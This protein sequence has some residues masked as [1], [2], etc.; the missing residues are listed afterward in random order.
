MAIA[1]RNSSGAY[2][3]QSSAT[4][5]ATVSRTITPALP[6][7]WQPGDL[8]IFRIGK[9]GINELA[10][11]PPSGWTQISSDSFSVYPTTPT[12][13]GFFSTAGVTE[14]QFMVC[15]RRLQARRHRAVCDVQPEKH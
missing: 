2:T 4:S 8:A 1:F 12:P 3:A 13:N 6:T 10:F 5:G 14:Q 7:G 11:T 9:T 15:Y